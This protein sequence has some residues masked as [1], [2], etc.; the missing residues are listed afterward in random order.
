MLDRRQASRAIAFEQ[1]SEC[2][3]VLPDREVRQPL[4]LLPQVLDR[5]ALAVQQ[6]ED[7]ASQRSAGQLLALR[8]RGV[9]LSAHQIGLQRR[10]RHQWIERDGPAMRRH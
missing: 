4:F 7:H 1:R 10:R 8:E 2:H 6:C 9:E 5:L 3:A